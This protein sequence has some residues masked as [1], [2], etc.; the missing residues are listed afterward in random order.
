[1]AN[2]NEILC[3]ACTRN[4]LEEDAVVFCKQCQEYYCT[5]CANYHKNFKISR[6]HVLLQFGGGLFSPSIWNGHSNGYEHFDLAEDRSS[7]A[8]GRVKSHRSSNKAQSAK[9]ITSIKSTNSSSFRTITD[10][11]S[12]FDVK[13]K[14]LVPKALGEFNVKTKNDTKPCF[15]TGMACLDDG[16]VVIVDYNNK[17]LKLFDKNYKFVTDLEAPF[18]S[19]GVAFVEGK[20]VAVSNAYKIDLYIIEPKKIQI[21][22]KSFKVSGHC[23]DISYRNGQ[24]ALAADTHTERPYVII[25]DYH[26]SLRYTCREIRANGKKTTKC[27]GIVIDPVD[28]GDTVIISDVKWNRV[29]CLSYVTGKALWQL[30]V[31]GSPWG[32]VFVDDYLLLADNQKSTI[33]NIDVFRLSKE[34]LL[35]GKNGIKNPSVI[36]VQH[37]TGRLLVTGSDSD[38]VKTFSLSSPTNGALS[39]KSDKN[40]EAVKKE[41]CCVIS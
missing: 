2:P 34:T 18:C 37:K 28:K 41:S 7:L 39:G 33:L 9:T 16:R 3:D 22:S 30:P 36:C 5:S 35:F 13:R 23:T 14:G 21:S 4:G 17:R 31:E 26:G 11:N 24:Y 10:Q 40:Q 1:M 32:L 20:I 27:H 19:W 8:S 12:R 15:V 29:V 6:L 25:L 38:V